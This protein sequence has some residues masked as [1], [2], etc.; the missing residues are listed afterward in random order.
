MPAAPTDRAG[1]VNQLQ[2]ASTTTDC[3]S[4]NLLLA[5]ESEW[6]MMA[7]LTPTGRDN[8]ATNLTPNEAA[9]VEIFVYPFHAA[10]T[11]DLV[12]YF[13]GQLGS[14]LSKAEMLDFLFEYE[15]AGSPFTGY[16]A[17]VSDAA[18]SRNLV[19]NFCYD[20]EIGSATRQSWADWLTTWVVNFRQPWRDG[21]RT[22]RSWSTATRAPTRPWWR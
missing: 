19:D 22:D 2:G 20:T 11:D 4:I 9:A 16:Y 12:D 1:R 17:G 14:G 10:P 13:A 5:G 18:F 15:Y 8:M 21:R 7:Y 6:F 3:K